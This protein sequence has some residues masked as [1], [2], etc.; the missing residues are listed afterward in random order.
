VVNGLDHTGFTVTDLARSIAFYRDLLGF[1]VFAE[2]ERHGGYF[3]RIVGYPDTD[4]RMACVRPRG[5]SHH[6]ELFQYVSPEP[7]RAELEPRRVGATHVCLTVDDLTGLYARLE[8]RGVSS[9]VSPPVAI[10]HG[11]NA[12][13]SALYLRDPDGI[14]LELFQPPER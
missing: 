5:A 11:V 10:D 1:E 3:G 6:I 13:G 7:R 2:G 4:V 8:E 12:G 14:I 9:F